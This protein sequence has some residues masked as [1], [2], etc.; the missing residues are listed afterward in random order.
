MLRSMLISVLQDFATYLGV[1]ISIPKSGKLMSTRI[2][3]RKSATFLGVFM[4]IPMYLTYS[5]FKFWNSR[6]EKVPFCLSY[7]H[8][9]YQ[10]NWGFIFYI[11]IELYLFNI[12]VNCKHETTRCASMK[13]CCWPMLGLVCMSVCSAP[14]LKK[15][16]WIHHWH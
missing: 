3:A 7:N 4:S 6:C 2:H 11:I 9:I 5:K 13:V 8:S 10:E 12:S 1:L 16:C 14:P 15:S